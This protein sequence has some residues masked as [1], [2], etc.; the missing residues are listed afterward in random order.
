M[1][2]LEIGKKIKQ[3]RKKAGLT[4]KELGKK[5]GRAESSIAQYESGKVEAPINVLQEICNACNVSFSLAMDDDSLD[6]LKDSVQSNNHKL[7]VELNHLLDERANGDDSK[8][9][10]E[11]IC[12]VLHKLGLNQNNENK[13]FGEWDKRII[14]KSKAEI[15]TSIEKLNHFGVSKIAEY[16]KDLT[17]IP[18]YRRKDFDE[19][20]IENGDPNAPDKDN[21]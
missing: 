10:D 15:A 19:Y 2:N 16:A 12:E 8:P 14:D 11:K 5:I 20:V 3:F 1:N 9:N 6:K 4:Q 7:L 18:Y 21:T 17:N 13:I